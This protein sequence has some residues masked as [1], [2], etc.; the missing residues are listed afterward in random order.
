MKILSISLLLL[1]LTEC[2]A[3]S[4]DK[5]METNDTSKVYKTENEW[6]KQLTPLQFHVTRE[7][8]TERPFSGKYDHFFEPGYYVCV[9][10]GTK[11]FDSE[12]KYNSGCG[13]PA[14]ND[15][16]S[17]KNIEKHIDTSFGM[18]RTEVTC[19]KCDAHLG[20]VFPDGPAPTGLRYCINSE[21]IRFVKK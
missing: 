18:I 20:H 19:A 16:A 13:W 14:F 9:C 8:G 17:L 21:A 15:A 7:K 1:T 2:K 10:C 11:L 6:R 4:N 5:N 12:H 3:Q